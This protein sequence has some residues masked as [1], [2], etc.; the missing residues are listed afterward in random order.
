MRYI[1]LKLCLWQSLAYANTKNNEISFFS[2]H[3]LVNKLAF[4]LASEEIRFHLIFQMCYKH[5]KYEYT[6]LGKYQ[7]TTVCDFF[8]SL[9]Y[10][11]CTCLYCDID[12]FSI[13]CAGLVLNTIWIPFLFSISLTRMCFN[14]KNLN[15]Y[16]RSHGSLFSLQSSLLSDSRFTVITRLSAIR[17]I[18]WGTSSPQ[19]AHLPLTLEHPALHYAALR[20]YI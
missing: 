6:E 20:L 17:L 13:Y 12:T 4:K 15:V 14:S 16:C 1:N 18:C 9:R 10:W 5:L 19:T 2:H 8:R 11:Y 7:T 3:D